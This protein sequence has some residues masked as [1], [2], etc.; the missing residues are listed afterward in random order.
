MPEKFEKKYFFLEIINKYFTQILFIP[1][2]LG[3][4]IQVIRLFMISPQAI[5]FFSPTQTISDGI[6]FLAIVLIYLSAILFLLLLSLPQG[7]ILILSNLDT[8][9]GYKITTEDDKQDKI[10]NK[11]SHESFPIWIHILIPIFV[12]SM[13]YYFFFFSD[14]LLKSN[15]L[16]AMSLMA[17]ALNFFLSIS[18][19]RFIYLKKEYYF[20]ENLKSFL[21]I[22]ITLCIFC[23]MFYSTY[24]VNK[25]NFALNFKFLKEKYKCHNSANVEIVYFNDKYIFLKRICKKNKDEIIIERIEAL[26]KG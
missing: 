8:Q 4:I 21:L 24:A 1:I 25:S 2:L 16:T 26:F 9:N 17:F 23:S 10:R 12:C 13:Y 22:N 18:L 20:I 19:M 7:L 6:F 3:G 11:L 14:S 5:R 15:N